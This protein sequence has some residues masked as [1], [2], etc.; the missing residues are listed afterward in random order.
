MGIY[1][2]LFQPFTLT[3]GNQIHTSCLFIAA[4]GG[5]TSFCLSGLKRLASIGRSNIT[6]GFK[7]FG[8]FQIVGVNI[9]IYLSIILFS[10]I[11][12]WVGYILAKKAAIKSWILK[13]VYEYFIVTRDQEEDINE[14]YTIN[15]NQCIILDN[16][17]TSKT[18][19]QSNYM[20]GIRQSMQVHSN[21]ADEIMQH[22][23]KANIQTS[24]SLTS[25]IS[26]GINLPSEEEYYSYRSLRKKTKYEEMNMNKKRKRGYIVGVALKLEQWK[27]DIVFSV[28]T[29]AMK[30][31]FK[32]NTGTLG[33]NGSN[34]IL[35]QSG[36]NSAL[37]Q[38]GSN[39]TFSEIKVID[40]PNTIKTVIVIGR[41]SPFAVSSSHPNLKWSKTSLQAP[42]NV[43][44]NVLKVWSTP[45]Q[46]EKGIRYMCLRELYT[47]DKIKS[48]TYVIL[49]NALK[50]DKFK[51]S[52]ELCV[53]I[54]LYM[55]N[56]KKN[57]QQKIVDLLHQ[58][59]DMFPGWTNKW[60]IYRTMK[61]IEEDEI[62]KFDLSRQGS[63]TS[64]E[65]A[66]SNNSQEHSINQKL[67]QA[68]AYTDLAKAH[69]MQMLQ[70]LIRGTVDMNRVVFHS[71]KSASNTIAAW[72]IF[73]QLLTDFPN[74]SNILRKFSVLV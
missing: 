30:H 22:T 54:A 47:N 19:T 67:S 1:V 8:W 14:N 64:F 70:L 65:Y 12:G 61:K 69:L 43:V 33:Y 42:P 17:N 40:I 21:C 20:K 27:S 7:L 71:V 34:S 68:S 11:L 58:A 55:I 48:F 50:K 56:F 25:Q 73:E 52:A 37:R 32:G 72:N 16:Q 29:R 60:I 10:L 44:S 66:F 38:S 5:L 13:P 4:G 9:I 18:Q 15:C 2:I 46:L 41:I 63:N 6:N 24:K 45:S 49:V 35:R 23:L 51:Y 74:K 28:E 57:L 36:S 59:S 3:F 39:S 62:R 31:F 53:T 26:Y